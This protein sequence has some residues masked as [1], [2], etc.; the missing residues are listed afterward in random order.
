MG[1]EEE[2]SQSLNHQEPVNSASASTDITTPHRAIVE[3]RVAGH[4]HELIT[5]FRNCRI[6]KQS[7][8]DELEATREESR[9]LRAELESV[10]QE[11]SD[12]RTQSNGATEERQDE[13]DTFTS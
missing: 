3:S 12:V 2:R 7:L 5:E 10:R 9:N 1:A 4:I 13:R 8:A 6:A 11:N